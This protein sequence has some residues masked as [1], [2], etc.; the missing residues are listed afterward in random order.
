[1]LLAVILIIL[2]SLRFQIICAVEAPSNSII[3]LYQKINA[4]GSLSEATSFRS[5]IQTKLKETNTVRMFSYAG[6]LSS[7][8]EF[9]LG[10][11][12]PMLFFF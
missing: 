2:T 12:Q 5:H 3:D 8:K 4:Y 7:V 10:K 11:I 6:L 9:D 1:M